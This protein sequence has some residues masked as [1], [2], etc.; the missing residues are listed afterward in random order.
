MSS[1]PRKTGG[2]R[3]N[4]KFVSHQKTGRIRFSSK[5]FARRGVRKAKIVQKQL[6]KK[7]IQFSQKSISSKFQDGKSVSGL[8]KGLNSGKIKVADYVERILIC[9]PQHTLE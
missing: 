7:N 2:I 3:K 9:R 4:P 6:H 5:G 1:G 8:I